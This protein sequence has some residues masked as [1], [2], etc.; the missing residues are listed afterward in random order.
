MDQSNIARVIQYQSIP[1]RF[2]SINFRYKFGSCDDLS[3]I[4]LNDLFMLSLPVKYDPIVVGVFDLL[5]AEVAILRFH[6]NILSPF[7][8]SRSRQ[9][10]KATFIL[11]QR[12]VVFLTLEKPC[13]KGTVQMQRLG[14]FLRY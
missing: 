13:A 2:H 3:S 9:R 1:K 12:V 4:L 14:T 10:S 8:F 7:P 11:R 5:L 6:L